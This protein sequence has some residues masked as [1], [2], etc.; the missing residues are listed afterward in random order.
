M[1]C[2]LLTLAAILVMAVGRYHGQTKTLVELKKTPV[3][4]LLDPD[5]HLLV[6]SVSDVLTLIV[7]LLVSQCCAPPNRESST[8]SRNICTGQD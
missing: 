3:V 4:E 5:Q 6:C 1:L 2:S 7:W 8:V